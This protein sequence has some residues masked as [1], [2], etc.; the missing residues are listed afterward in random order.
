MVGAFMRIGTDLTQNYYEIDLSGL[1][2][3]WP[4]ASLPEEVWPESNEI[5]IALD[6]LIQ[7]KA[8][9]NRQ[10]DKNLSIPYT[11]T[12]ADG[13]F[14]LTV[15]GNP[16]LSAVRVMMIGMRNPKSADERSKS[17]CIWVDEMHV[18]GFDDKG[19]IAAIA[20]LNAK[21]ADFATV[22]ASG[23]LETFGFWNRTAANR[24]TLP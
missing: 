15:V 2:A 22:T 20:Q 7:A 21:L 8:L 11:I 10:L 24:R 1:K 23:R 16:D 12:T 18:E 9:R 4:T 19:G 6:D 14:K 5:N 13:R 17:F 3:T